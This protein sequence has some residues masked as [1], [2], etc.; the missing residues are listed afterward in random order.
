MKH[1]SSS[2]RITYS[3]LDEDDVRLDATLRPRTFDEFVG[4]QRTVDNLRVYIAAAK[5]RGEPVDHIILSGMPGLGKT[6]L[7][8]LIAREVGTT[9]KATS[10]PAIERA[11]DLVGLLTNLKRGDI[12]FIDEI[13]R[14]NTTVEEYLY[15]AMEDFKI[16]IIIDQGPNA[17]SVKINIEPFTLVGATTREGLLS[18]PFRARFGVFER[19]DVYPP[20]DLA[21]ILSRSARILEVELD[22]E[23]RFM[24]ASRA[25]GVPRIA[26]RCLRRIRDLAQVRSANR[27]TPE[28]AEEGL[29]ML[30]IDKHGLETLDRMILQTLIKLGGG[31]V[32]LK[33]IAISVGEEEDTIEEIYEPYL[34]R[35]GFIEK[36]PRGRKIT[37]HACKIL[38]MEMPHGM[39][40]NL[41]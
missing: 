20:E 18:S 7:A 14:L 9:I 1:R 31:P 24:I 25:R 37:A 12:L 41:F 30:G 32:G 26:N 15:S 16:D 17:R 23:A 4:Q 11:G 39:Q 5:K 27:I 28:I 2:K 40:K 19:L 35:Q 10:G 8:Y 21:K 33:T 29:S 36:T 22:D 6:T 3:H 38:G 13:H 34:I